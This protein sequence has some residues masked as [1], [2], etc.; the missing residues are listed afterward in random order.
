M[1]QRIVPAGRGRARRGPSIAGDGGAARP[2]GRAALGPGRVDAARASITR[3]RSEEAGFTLVELLVVVLV[4]GALVAIAVPTFIGQRE[5]AW[6]AALRSELRAASIALESYRAQNGQYSQQALTSGWG[7]EA[8]GSV[9]FD[10]DLTFYLPDSYCII[11][12]HVDALRGSPTHRWRVTHSGGLERIAFSS[13][14]C[15][16]PTL[17]APGA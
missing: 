4:L 15:T 5:S 13:G 7:Y 8:S 9:E 3:M 11:G 1:S 16:G 12:D 6:D 10:P 17:P 14:N 2:T